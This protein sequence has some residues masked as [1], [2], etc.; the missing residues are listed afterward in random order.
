MRVFFRGIDF[1]TA[2]VDVRER[3]AFNREESVRTAR[4]LIRAGAP[5]A[6]VLSTCNRSEFYLAGAS[7]GELRA[8]WERVLG[9]RPGSDVPSYWAERE[10]GAAVSHLF[11]VCAGMDSMVLGEP[12]IL[13]QAKEAFQLAREIGSSGPL[14]NEAFDRAVHAAKRVRSETSIGAGAVSLASVTRNVLAHDLG[15]L[16]GKRVL[17]LGTGDIAEQAARSLLSAGAGCLTVMSRALER[18]EA[19]A[20]R[21]GG[22]AADISQKCAELA[23][24]DAAVCASSAPYYLVRKCEAEELFR[25]RTGS[26]TASMVD[27]SHPR[28]IDPAIRSLSGVRLYALDDLRS[29]I[30]RNLE[31]RRQELPDAERI[32]QAESAQLS[33]WHASLP[34]EGLVRELRAKTESAR[35]RELER[36]A[37]GLSDAE[38]AAVDEATRRVVQKLLHAPTL[39]AKSLDADRPDHAERVAL[40]RQ[41]FDLE[42]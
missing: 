11:R 30:D 17:L 39:A 7:L 15:G 6:L 1:R 21:T 35:L 37:S 34:M 18:A 31:R 13:G 26:R 16:E 42:E 12:E 19:F 9:G 36:A 3:F 22:K 23:R 40:F 14:L 28:N 8:A 25:S 20:A 32:I 2:P 41:I 33:R 29:E 5:E 10:N 24:A 4:A 27:L 38:R